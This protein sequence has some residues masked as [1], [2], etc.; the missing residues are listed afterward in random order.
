MKA[1]VL[2]VVAI[3]S[4]LGISQVDATEVMLW[5]LDEL[6][7]RSDVVAIGTITGTWLDFRPFEDR[8]I[9]DTANLKISEILKGDVDSDYLN[10]RFYGDKGKA[11]DN[12]FGLYRGHIGADFQSGETV[13]VFLGHE[14]S[15]MVMGEGYYSYPNG[16]YVIKDQKVFSDYAEPDTLV[17]LK[18]AIQHSLIDTSE[19]ILKPT[20]D[21]SLLVPVPF[22]G[23]S[24]DE[25]VETL[26]QL[27]DDSNPEKTFDSRKRSGYTTDKGSLKISKEATYDYSRYVTYGLYGKENALP[28]ENAEKFVDSLM[29]DIGYDRDGSEH[30]D[31]TDFGSKKEMVIQQKKDGWIIANE[32]HRFSFRDD[33]TSIDLGRWYTNL[34]EFE[35]KYSQDDAKQIAYDFILTISTD[36]KLQGMDIQIVPPRNV[37]MKVIQDHLVYAVSGIYFHTDVHVDVNSG[38]I[39]NADVIKITGQETPGC[40]SVGVKKLTTQDVKSMEKRVGTLLYYELTDDDLGQLSVLK[41]MID[42]TNSRIEYNDQ[43]RL[44]ISVDEWTEYASFFKEKFDEQHEV[45]YESDL[46]SNYVLYGDRVYT[47]RYNENYQDAPLQVEIFPEN[48]DYD[49]R[50]ITITEGEIINRTPRFKE[51]IDLMGTWEVSVR[52]STGILESE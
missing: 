50:S 38:E 16:K 2:V 40:A 36:S 45:Y 49:R 28:K 17:N 48:F 39:V 47:A 35:I 23:F 30:V 20:S 51:S 15:T 5:P 25:I 13:L 22:V 8:K 34:D 26:I 9:V 43:V 21:E 27:T 7:K 41:E 18:N 6:T 44:P 12:F 24:E 33:S 1:S 11:F 10:I 37:E 46:K 32:I 4:T 52:N 3:F 19:D 14:D 42:A 29:K 31:F